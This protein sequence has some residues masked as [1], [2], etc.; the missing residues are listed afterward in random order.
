M[1]N[2]I[3]KKEEKLKKK[4][5]QK[6]EDKKCDEKVSEN[7]RALDVNANLENAQKIKNSDLQESKI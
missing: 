3:N 5:I 4:N 6:K 1:K 7:E 2:Q